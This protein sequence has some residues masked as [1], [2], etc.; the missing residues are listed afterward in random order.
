MLRFWAYRLEPLLWLELELNTFAHK[1]SE[2]RYSYFSY[3]R[4][5]QNDLRKQKSRAMI[6]NHIENGNEQ[7][8]YAVR[9]RTESR[10]SW[11]P[12]GDA[13]RKFACEPLAERVKTQ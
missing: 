5:F 13:R 8:K 12:A 11:K 1:N 3:L 6:R 2:E 10:G 9:K 4:I 7:E